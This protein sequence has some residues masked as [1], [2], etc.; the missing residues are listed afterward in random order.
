MAP[1][2]VRT[3]LA[4]IVVLI[5]VMSVVGCSRIGR[6]IGAA[7]EAASKGS[8]L[9]GAAPGTAQGEQP[10]AGAAGSFDET[11]KKR[12]KLTSYELTVEM[13]GQQMKQIMKME[14]GEMVRVKTIMGDE[15]TWMIVLLD[16]KVQYI[17]DEKQKTAMKMPVETEDAD[18]LANMGPDVPDFGDV[19]A[20]ARNMK[21]DT[22]DGVECWM[23]E[24]P[25]VGQGS[26]A[27]WVDKEYGLMRQMKAG[28]NIVKHNY[29]R[30]NAVPDS[31]F[32]LPP[33]TKI[34]DMS[35]M[36]KGVPK[37]PGA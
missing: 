7:K 8:A 3:A 31:E 28:D 27:V 30:I 29:T 34:Q 36:M 4:A 35:D 13:D 26:M 19:P 23:I 37:P 22:V 6:I 24:A 9:P 20:D 2:A 5:M 14:N 10:S 25:N 21:S 15:G 11:L 1:R 16:K 12:A 33:G 17:Y 32:E 18:N